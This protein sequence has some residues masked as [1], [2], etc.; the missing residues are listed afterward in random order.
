MSPQGNTWNTIQGLCN[1]NLILYYPHSIILLIHHHQSWF[2]SQWAQ[3]IFKQ[4]DTF[5]TKNM[6][7]Q[8]IF[9]CAQ[10]NV[11]LTQKYSS[12]VAS[13]PWFLHLVWVKWKTHS[14]PAVVIPKRLL[15]PKGND[16]DYETQDPDEDEVAECLFP[17]GSVVV[18]GEHNAQVLLQSHVGQKHDWHL[19]GQHGQTANQLALQAL[20]PQLGVSVV[21]STVLDVKR[22][23]EEQVDSHEAVST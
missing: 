19:S 11:P 14:I 9:L 22:T 5:S 1:S 2:L 7:F 4:K 13:G 17:S 10:T 6:Y 21:L 8:L 23:D 18:E 15:V 12:G 20:H 16:G 3:Y